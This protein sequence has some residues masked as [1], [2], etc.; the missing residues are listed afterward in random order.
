MQVQLA[1]PRVHAAVGATLARGQRHVVE[2]EWVVVVGMEKFAE[3]RERKFFGERLRESD[4]GT[5]EV[6][7]TDIQS[8]SPALPKGGGRMG[9][10]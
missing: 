3:G 5:D 9:D 6:E 1:P 7:R 10:G 8:P 4:R 2:R